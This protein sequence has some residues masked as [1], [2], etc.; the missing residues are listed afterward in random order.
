MINEQYCRVVIVD[1]ELLIRQGIKHYI[2]WEQEGFRIVGEASNGR[3]ALELISTTAPHIV[4]TDIVMPIMDGEELTRSIK[5]NY[6]HTEVIIL[7]SFGEFDYVR[8]TFQSGVVDYILKPKL[9]GKILLEALKKAVSRIP[10]FQLLTQK[11][12]ANNFENNLS[13][14]QVISKL[15]SGYEVQLESQ[16]LSRAFP[17]DYYCLLGVSLKNN[18]CNEEANLI[19]NKQKAI[20][21][22]L[23]LNLSKTQYYS[24]RPEE[25]LLVF[26]INFDKSESA[27]LF[28]FIKKLAASD[29]GLSLTMTKKFT[30]MKDLSTIYKDDLMKLLR[31]KFY[32]PEQQLLLQEE[33]PNPLPKVESFNLEWFTNEFKREQFDSAF[34]YLE[35]FIS[36]FSICFTTDVYEFKAFFNNIIFNITILLSN[37]NYDIGDLDKAKYTSF[38]AIDEAEAAEVVLQEWNKFLLDARKQIADSRSQTG[39]PNMKKLLLYIADHYAEPITLTDVAQHFHFNPSY[40]SNYFATHNKEGFIEHLNNIRIKEATKLLTNNSAA[41]SEI[42][43]LVGYSDHSYFCRVFKKKM[44]MSP[45]QY[46][47]KQLLK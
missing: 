8:S 47:R 2:N 41:I 45:S 4:I 39:N 12:G 1:D 11:N 19:A 31:Y 10:N 26:V 42:G 29:Q 16:L 6:S 35:E 24:F 30:R 23:S 21:K 3:E 37:M 43:S 13:I 28:S 9:N 20:E 18:R 17:H 34:T 25:Y 40:L 22:A 14:E 36:S 33:L 32:F 5:E 7:S 15:I 27:N 38:K 44:G 46:R